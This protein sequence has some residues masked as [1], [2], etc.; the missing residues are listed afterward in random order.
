MSARFVILYGIP[1]DVE[2]F[3]RHYRQVHVPL[4]RALPGLRRYTLGR[5]VRMVR[6]DDPYHLV[7]ELEWDDMAALQAAFASPEG[8][9]AAADMATVT[10][11]ALVR[12]MIYEATDA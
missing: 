10:A 12:S 8:R 1:H 4:T 3:E 2:E 9:A 7:A 6:G 5:G 11:L